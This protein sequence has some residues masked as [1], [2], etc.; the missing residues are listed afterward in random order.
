MTCPHCKKETI[1]ATAFECY[2][3]KAS[4]FR[5]VFGYLPPGKDSCF[6]RPPDAFKAWEKFSRIAPCVCGKEIDANWGDS[7]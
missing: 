2:E 1:T 7:L 6:P 3:L 4:T 5:K